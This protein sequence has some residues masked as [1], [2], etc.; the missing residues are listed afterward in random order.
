M[1]IIIRIIITTNWWSINEGVYKRKCKVPS[2]GAWSFQHIIPISYLK[3]VFLLFSK[4]KVN[5]NYVS[6]WLPYNIF[7]TNILSQQNDEIKASLSTMYFFHN[8]LMLGI[9]RIQSQTLMTC[10]STIISIQIHCV[11]QYCPVHSTPE[12]RS[13]WTLL[14]LLLTIKSHSSI[15]SLICP[16]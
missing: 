4:R 12:S 9:L 16:A 5:E 6:F 8:L 14:Y 13:L 3:W 7:Y 10:L 2:V 1:I 11:Q 15:P